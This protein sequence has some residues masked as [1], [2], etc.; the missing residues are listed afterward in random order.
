MDHFPRP[1]L[2]KTLADGLQGRAIFGDC[3]SGLF[4]AAPRRTGKSTFLQADLRPEL[5]SRDIL[6]VYCDLWAD[7]KRDP[8]ALISE[9]IGAAITR[10]LGPV[11][12]TAKSMG[13]DE[14]NIAGTL[15]IDTKKIGKIEGSTLADALRT[16]RQAS[17]K[18]VALIIDEAQQA[19]T[20]DLGESAMMALKSAR[21]QMN[22]PGEINLMLIM[23]GSDRDKL[24]R[25]VNT[26]SAPFYGSSIQKMPDLGRDFIEHVAT[27]IERQRPDL[28]PADVDKLLVA[29]NL[30]SC[31]PQ[32]FAQALGE[33]LN[34]LNASSARFEDITLRAAMQRSLD[35]EQQMASDFV[36]LKPLE[37]A[38]L[39][40]L[41]EQ[42]S[43]FRPYDAEALN[44]YADSVGERVTPAQIQHVLEALRNRMPAL[45]WK[46][47]RGE[48]AIDEAMMY[49]WYSKRKFDGTWPPVAPERPPPP[50]S[51]LNRL[52]ARARRHAP[53]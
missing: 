7:Q 6:V 16:L 23:S 11:A 51:Q 30:F 43:R 24:L 35:D 20:S 31:R 44:F 38:V 42:G 5:E 39:W 14:V 18:S 34:P 4:L 2:A 53:A 40:R 32:F 33:V 1:I 36:A 26:T 52:R 15:K 25:L 37:Q 49:P 46:S 13:L 29:F 45:V 3:T 19:L 27:L 21:D 10:V 9:A 50:M 47:A 12:K 17:K 41:L 8:A 28:V 48:Y 22:Q